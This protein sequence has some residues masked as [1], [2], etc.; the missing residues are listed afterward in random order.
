MKNTQVPLKNSLMLFLT[1]EKKAGFITACYIVIV[2][3]L[4]L[5]IKK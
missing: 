1:A 3:I 2:P 5:F 4:G